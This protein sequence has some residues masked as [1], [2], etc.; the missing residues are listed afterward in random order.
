MPTVTEIINLYSTAQYLAAVDIAKSGLNAKGVDIN[1]PY[2][3]YNIGKS[4][5]ERYSKDPSDTSLTDTANY[6]YALCGKYGILAQG[7]SGVAGNSVVSGSVTSPEPY[8]FIVD[9]SSFMLNGESSKTITSFIGYNLLY[10]RNGI[11]QTT[12][13]TES[14]YFSWDKVTGNFVTTPALV[15]GELILL[16][17]I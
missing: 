16:A 6:L 12:V 10:V 13:N 8:N 11:P 3:I 2:K 15:T 14:S 5:S 7:V 9:G 17:A 1:L 4:V